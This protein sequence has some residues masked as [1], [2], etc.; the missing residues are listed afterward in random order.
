MLPCPGVTFFRHR[1]QHERHPRRVGEADGGDRRV[2]EGARRAQRLRQMKPIVQPTNTYTGGS[3]IGHD[4][5][6]TSGLACCSIDVKSLHG[7]VTLHAELR[8][9]PDHLRLQDPPAR[10]PHARRRDDK[11]LQHR[12]ERRDERLER[13]R[14]GLGVEKSRCR[15]PPPTWRGGGEARA[16]AQRPRLKC[17]VEHANCRGDLP[18]RR[19]EARAPTHLAPRYLPKNPSTGGCPRGMRLVLGKRNR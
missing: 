2:E 4:D 14:P 17:G 12:L 1:Q 15:C 13:Q 16:C 18:L 5:A 6:I 7:S 8:E 10:H 11:R 9:R 3:R 19:R